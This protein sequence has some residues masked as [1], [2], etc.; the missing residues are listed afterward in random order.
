MLVNGSSR[1]RGGI[2]FAQ[3]SNFAAVLLRKLFSSNTK[4]WG[5]LDAETARAAKQ[6]LLELAGNGIG[7]ACE[8]ASGRAGDLKRN[9]VHAGAAADERLRRSLAH[10]IVE[11]GSILVPAGTWPE[12][13][14]MV[15]Y[16]VQ[17]RSEPLQSL[18]MKPGSSF[19][20]NR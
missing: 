17:V 6:A 18:R 3:V 5:S 8:R 10:A 4:W 19:S 16:G 2:R 15:F 7:P 12:L 1:H 9:R 14:Q 13:L 11:L 20:D